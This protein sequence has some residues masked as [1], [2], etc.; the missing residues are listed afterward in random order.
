[1][2]TISFYETVP[3]ASGVNKPSRASFLFQPTKALVNGSEETLPIPFVVHLD[4][5]G[6]AI[7]TLKETDASWAWKVTKSLSGMTDDVEYVA[8]KT[9]DTQWTSLA[10]LDPTTLTPTATPEAAWWAMA[11]STITD[12]T[13]LPTGH[14]Q[15]TRNDG[16]TIIL[17]NVV[18]PTGATGPSGAQ[19]PAGPV[20]P[21]GPQG[22]IGPEGPIGETGAQGPIGLTG[23]QGPQGQQ[24]PTGLTGA[25]GPT[26]PQG[27]TGPT[28]ATGPQGPT[29]ATGPTGPTGATGP[30]GVLAN[31]TANQAYNVG[32]KVLSPAN[33]VVVSRYATSSATYNASQW[34]YH[35]NRHIEYTIAQTLTSGTVTTLTGY[36]YDASSSSDSTIVAIASGVITPAETGLYDIDASF[37]TPSGVS[38]VSR[39]FAQLTDAANS[40]ANI[41]RTPGGAED[42]FSLSISGVLLTGGHNYHVQA[43]TA[44]TSGTDAMTG[45]IRFTFKG[46]VAV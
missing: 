1:M 45:R 2:A 38:G 34:T 16:S 4:R 6:K 22:P 26:G 28:G 37:F 21:A 10:R 3:D 23:P 27:A 25:T 5:N 7:V 8:V 40:D 29:G 39:S 33:E 36:T 41:K 19:G 20:G 11:N 9:T 30:A 43:F 44:F 15:M 13:V 32:D 14:L 46:R 24:G 35:G 42:A 17:G 18:G 31:W 12:A